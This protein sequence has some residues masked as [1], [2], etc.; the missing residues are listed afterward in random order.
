M[1]LLDLV[2]TALTIVSVTVVVAYFGLA[3]DTGLFTVLPESITGFFLGNDALQ[4]VAVV[5]LVAGLVGKI[6]VGRILKRRRL[7]PTRA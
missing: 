6:L 5:V 7:E 4:R 2:L 1:K 3:Y